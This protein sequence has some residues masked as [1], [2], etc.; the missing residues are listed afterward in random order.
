MEQHSFTYIR[1]PLDKQT[2]NKEKWECEQEHFMFDF[3]IVW[4]VYF[5]RNSVLQQSQ[6]AY[7][8]AHRLLFQ[9]ALSTYTNF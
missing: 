3:Y 9:W 4:F 5:Q 1:P 7:S 2:N 8:T 6:K